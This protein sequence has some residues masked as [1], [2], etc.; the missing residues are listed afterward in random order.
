MIR[1]Y[2]CLLALALV[3]AGASAV[4]GADIV[5]FY[6]GDLDPFNPNAN[7]LANERNTAIGRSN[8]YQNFIVPTGQTWGVHSLFSNDLVAPD[9][10]S[11]LPVFTSA[12]WSIRTGVSAGNSGSVVASGTSPV[13]VTPTGRTLFGMTEYN[14]DVLGLNITLGP[15]MYWMNV[16]PVDSGTGRSLNSDTQGLN[17]IGSQVTGQQFWDSP[18]TLPTGFGQTFANSFQPGATTPGDDRFSD[19]IDGQIVSIPEPGTLL[20]TGI[21]LAGLLGYRARRRK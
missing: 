11:A 12:D 9:N 17:A 6:G 5:L 14:F 4:R 7:A 15:G 8:V 19:G 10:N 13:I 3:L 1:R 21:G 16:T 20:L 18:G 2:P